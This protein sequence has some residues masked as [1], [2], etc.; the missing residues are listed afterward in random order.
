MATARPCSMRSASAS[1]AIRMNEQELPFVYENDLQRRAD[2]G[3]RD[4]RGGSSALATLQAS[5][6]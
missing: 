2:H 4:R 1:C 5:I 3:D 6:I